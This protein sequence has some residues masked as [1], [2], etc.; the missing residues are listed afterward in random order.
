MSDC[1]TSKLSIEMLTCI[2]NGEEGHLWVGYSH[3]MYDSEGNLLSS[4]VVSKSLWY[5]N[6]E[7][8]TWKV[9]SIREHP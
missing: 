7:N 8:E 6:K 5:I 2:I 1:R 9:T 4:S 3:N